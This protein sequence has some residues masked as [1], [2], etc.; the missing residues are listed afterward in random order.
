M[1]TVKVLGTGCANCKTTLKLIEEAAKSKGLEVQL[2]KVED[3]AAI[4]SYGVMST[5]G[6]VGDCKMVLQQM[7]EAMGS[8]VDGARYAAWRKKLAD[9]DAAKRAAGGPPPAKDGEP[10]HPLQLC[11]EVKDFMQRDAIRVVD[12]QEILNYGRHSMPT[13]APGHRL[14]SGPFGT[15]GVGLPFGLGA[16]VAKPDAQVIVVHGDGETLWTLTHARD[17]A[18]GFVGLMGNPAAIG[19]TFHI[20]SDFVYTWNQI[21]RMIADGLG[22]EAKLV[23]VPSEVI[24]NVLPPRG[25]GLLGDKAHCLLF[26]NTKLKR[27]VPDFA[28]RI[29]F[30]EGV[31][32]SVAWYEAHPEKKVSDQAIE[33]EVETVLKGWRAMMERV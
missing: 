23:H 25:P 31:R 30:Q 14:N 1:K 29:P 9:G 20:T 13:F 26:D 17:F 12:G 18:P 11:E 16:K 32:M 8:R 5:P 6:V 27:L 19:E 3:I 2:D 15:M 10:I 33:A 28:P 22:V 24:A 21:H 4:M 7:L